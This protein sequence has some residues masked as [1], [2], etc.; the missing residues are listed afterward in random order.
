MLRSNYFALKNYLLISSS[1]TSVVTQTYDHL[2]MY[3]SIK[4]TT[5]RLSLMHS[6]KHTTSTL[7]VPGIEAER[8]T[9]TQR[10]AEKQKHKDTH[11]HTETEPQRETEG[12]SER[13]P[14]HHHVARDNRSL[15]GL[16]PAKGGLE[17]QPWLEG[18]ACLQFPSFAP[19]SDADH[20][21]PQPGDNHQHLNTKEES[22][23][24]GVSHLS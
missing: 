14:L 18:K 9:E 3:K 4:E 1:S 22:H 8:E 20:H 21:F 2:I 17:K 5:T 10:A 11:T 15:R 13:L 12:K 7:T 6:P 16:N 19:S 24:Q 23:L